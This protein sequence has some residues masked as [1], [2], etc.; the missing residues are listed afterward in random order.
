M[1]GD[2]ALDLAAKRLERALL[3]LEQ[4]LAERLKQ[5]GEEVG[6]LFDQDRAKLAA[7]LDESRA[8]ERALEAAGA[9]ASAALGRAILEIKQ[10]LD[11]AGPAQ[12]Q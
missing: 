11:G 7:E 2:S 8:R 4:R 1:T 3:M 9:E 6:G 12:E 10:A 5:A